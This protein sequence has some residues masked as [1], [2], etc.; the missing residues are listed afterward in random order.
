[1]FSEMYDCLR[2]PKL[3]NKDVEMKKVMECMVDNDNI[4]STR[5]IVAGAKSNHALA[6]TFKQIHFLLL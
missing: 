2:S 6:L 1:M 4:V 3:Q 5:T